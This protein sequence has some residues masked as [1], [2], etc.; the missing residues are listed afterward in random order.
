MLY[1]VK[2]KNTIGRVMKFSMPFLTTIG[3][4]KMTDIS[5][6]RGDNCKKKETCFRYQASESHYQSWIDPDECMRNDFYLYWT[7][8]NKPILARPKNEME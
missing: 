3:E 5:K 8:A 7:T 1:W 4:T 6:C 2:S